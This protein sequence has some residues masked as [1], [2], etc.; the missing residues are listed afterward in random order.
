M[1]RGTDKA[2]WEIP[3]MMVAVNTPLGSSTAAVMAAATDK[4]DSIG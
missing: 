3:V 4:S 2:T 1:R